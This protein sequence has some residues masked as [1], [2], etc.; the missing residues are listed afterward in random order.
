VNSKWARWSCVPLVLAGLLS[1]FQTAEAQ[2]SP[3]RTTGSIPPES[4]TFPLAS[5][6]CSTTRTCVGIGAQHYGTAVGSTALTTSDGGSTWASTS[7]LSGVK[8]LN[9]L[10]CASM[11]T[12]VAVGEYPLGNSDGGAVL[13]TLDGGR[14]WV[15]TSAL[16][17]SVGRLVGVSCPTKAFCMAVGASAPRIGAVAIVS[18]SAGRK[19]KRVALPKGEDDLSLVSCT[20]DRYCI[21]E[22]EVEATVGD[23]TSGDRVSIITTANGGSSWKQSSLMTNSAAP[24]G[25]PVFSGLTCA[26]STH[27]LLVGDATPGDGSPSGMIASSTDRGASWTFQAVP[28]GTTF[29]NAISCGSPTQCVVA[30]GGIEAR[31]GGDRDILTTSDGG[32]TWISRLV[33]TSAVGLEGVSCLSMTWCVAVGFGL[34][35]TDPTAQPAA[36]LVSSDG[37]ATWNAAP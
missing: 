6:V 23:S 9:A 5:V 10:A 34:S 8:Y 29:L 3:Q 19:W 31:G 28:L 11:R 1:S 24:V 15:L 7:I 32:R 18:D 4:L 17:K 27:C 35:V 37:G 30:G 20:T 14:T 16:P 22:G 36:V 25:I 2:A 12:C 13:R 33:P 21:A 26:T